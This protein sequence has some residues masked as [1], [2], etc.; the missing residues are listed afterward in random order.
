MTATAS[1][2]RGIDSSTDIS[3]KKSPWRSVAITVRSLALA[4]RDLDDPRLDHE[5]VDA[6]VA[7]A[8]H[9]LARFGDARQTTRLRA[10]R[11]PA[12]PP[13]PTGGGSSRSA[14]TERDLMAP[15]RSASSPGAHQARV[16]ASSNTLTW[17]SVPPLGLEPRTCGLRVRRSDQ[18]S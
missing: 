14:P 5:H 6:L 17:A 10:P 12:I 4:T 8:E 16:G 11:R 13:L 3:P 7:L 15:R 9:D 18:L 2:S 1:A